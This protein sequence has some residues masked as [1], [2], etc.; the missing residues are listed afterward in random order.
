MSRATEGRH[1]VYPTALRAFQPTVLVQTTM[2]GTWTPERRARAAE[3]MHR[4]KP[5]LKAAGPTT[6]AGK[7]ACARNLPAWTDERRAKAA[8]V[9]NQVKP[10]QSSTGPRTPEGKAITSMNAY[11]G[12]QRPKARARQRETRALLKELDA[13][14]LELAAH[15][16]SFYGMAPLTDED[17]LAVAAD[18]ASQGGA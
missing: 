10:W 3:V 17:L 11:R 14:C 1:P 18:E 7:A 2:A 6:E 9:T 12:A 8:E 5:W 16:L 4:V 15:G 13:A